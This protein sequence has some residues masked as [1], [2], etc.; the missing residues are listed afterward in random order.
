[1]P[2]ASESCSLQLRTR[3]PLPLAFVW[4]PLSPTLRE[5]PPNS[6]PRATNPACFNRFCAFGGVSGGG[7]GA[8]QNNRVT[9]RHGRRRFSASASDGLLRSICI[10]L[11]PMFPTWKWISARQSSSLPCSPCQTSLSKRLGGLGVKLAA[12]L[13]MHTIMSNSR[14]L[15]DLSLV[16][17]RSPPPLHFPGCRSGSEVGSTCRR[18]LAREC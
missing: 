15:S 8:G 16:N 2:E 17:D 11:R 12:C 7:G 18:R 14:Q 4:L 13:I 3:R 1:M 5:I 6:P 10:E 9:G